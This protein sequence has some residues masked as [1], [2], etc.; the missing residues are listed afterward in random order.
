ME[1]KVIGKAKMTLV[2]GKSM[3]DIL[4]QM[5][6]VA[7]RLEEKENRS[8]MRSMWDFVAKKPVIG[9]RKNG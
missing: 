5:E 7:D 2:S 4:K 8:M 6:R 3:G 1:K 9:K